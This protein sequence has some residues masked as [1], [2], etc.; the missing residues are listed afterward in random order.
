[1]EN[2]ITAFDQVFLFNTYPAEILKIET[3]GSSLFC[4]YKCLELGAVKPNRYAGK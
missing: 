4:I 2:I 3:I 1:M